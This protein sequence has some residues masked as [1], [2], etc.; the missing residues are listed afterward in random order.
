MQWTEVLWERQLSGAMRASQEEPQRNSPEEATPE[1]SPS[2]RHLE[3]PVGG[4]KERASMW[5]SISAQR[6]GYKCFVCHAQEFRA[7]PADDQKKLKNFQKE[8]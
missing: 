6:A 8:R 3:F 4:G 1:P 2:Q 5:D 7:L